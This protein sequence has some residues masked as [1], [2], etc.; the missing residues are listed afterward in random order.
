MDRFVLMMVL[1][2][3]ILIGWMT[4]ARI[5]NMPDVYVL[6]S[7]QLDLIDVNRA[8]VGN[9]ALIP[10]GGTLADDICK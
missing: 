7:H 5:S 1:I 8:C 4:T 9:V 3:G 2:A 6:P 10:V